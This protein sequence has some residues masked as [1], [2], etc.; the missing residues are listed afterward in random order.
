MKMMFNTN[1]SKGEQIPATRTRCFD[2]LSTLSLCSARALPSGSVLD[3]RPT[4]KVYTSISKILDQLVKGD[5]R[6]K[7]YEPPTGWSAIGKL[8]SA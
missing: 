8:T 7:K 4:K 2:I 6:K 5:L 3:G 1:A